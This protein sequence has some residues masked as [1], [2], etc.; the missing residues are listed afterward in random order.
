MDESD[1]DATASLHHS[2]AEKRG[3]FRSGERIANRYVVV[4]F[5]ARGG[6]GDV[7][8]A[9]DEHLQGKHIALKTLRAEIAADSEMQA[10]FERE[11]LVAREIS[12]RAICPTCASA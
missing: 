7:Y 4:Q 5:L 11:V 6:M 12:H 3:Q 1:R 9:I 10:R 8:E 2:P